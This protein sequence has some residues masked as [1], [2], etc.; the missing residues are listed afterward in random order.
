MCI[1]FVTFV[2]AFLLKAHYVSS[3]VSFLITGDVFL[4]VAGLGMLFFS[5]GLVGKRLLL[6]QLSHQQPPGVGAATLAFS[7]IGWYINFVCP[8]VGEDFVFAYPDLSPLL[9][10]FSPTAAYN[11][12]TQQWNYT[13]MAPT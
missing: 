6:S 5:N 3:L 11:S 1:T 2:I 13:S 7:H 8:Y 12:Y 9:G 4:L 10:T